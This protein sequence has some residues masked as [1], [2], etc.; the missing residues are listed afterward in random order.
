[1][2]ARTRILQ[3]VCLA[4]A[5]TAFLA[6]GAAAQQAGKK[7]A[8]PDWFYKNIVGY[9]AVKPLV[10]IPK[11]ES[12][13]II[14]SR[15]YEPKFVEGYIPTAVSIPDSQFEKMTGKLPADKNATL[16][17]YCG[18]LDCKLSHNSAKKAEALGYTNIKVYAEGYPD[19]VKKAPYVAVGVEYVHAL[20]AKGDK[21]YL[22]VDAR[23]HNKFLEGSI[24]SS[25]NIPET[26]FAA[27]K[28]MLPADKKTPLIFYCGGYDCKLSHKEAQEARKMGYAD[29]MVC[30]AGY[31]A[32]TEKYGAPGAAAIKTGG[33]EGAA[34]VEAFKKALAAGGE[35]YVIIDV[36]DADEY[37]AGH[38]P[39]SKNIQV[40]NLEPEIASLPTDKPVVFVCGTGAR[41][42]EA[43]YMVMDKRPD[44]K[45]V[46]YVE[47]EIKFHKDGSV[48]ITPTK[49]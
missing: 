41:S 8:T 24:P 42:G 7:A 22:L 9:D 39:S 28:G 36:R 23:P 12:A 32:W 14:D 10:T 48:D 5:L 2:N 4:L 17:F 35:G 34:D 3:A 13:M 46:F 15:P 40:G 44:M 19:Y 6:T 30:E 43:F 1:M 25:V 31:P 29:I 45:N 11:P 27:H 49:K 26:G 20:L 38:I 21:P 16:I 47:G 18:G 37:A 33:P